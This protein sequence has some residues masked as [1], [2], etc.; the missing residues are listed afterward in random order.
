MVARK[1]ILFSHRHNKMIQVHHFKYLGETIQTVLG[2]QLIHQLKKNRQLLEG[3]KT[4]RV[5]NTLKKQMHFERRTI[6]AQPKQW[7]S[8]VFPK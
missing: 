7:K 1:L 2:S 8:M 3:L 5:T 4:N 6:K